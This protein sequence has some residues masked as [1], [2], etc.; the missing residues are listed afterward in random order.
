MSEETTKLTVQVESELEELIPGF[1]RNRFNDVAKIEEHLQE[2]DFESIKQIGHT[3]KGNGAGYG[4]EEIS[5][6]GKQIESAAGEQKSE[7]VRDLISRL[8]SYLNQVSIEY[9]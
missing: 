3:M 4:F 8:S 6:I 7:E 2:D 1:I 9:I 5:E